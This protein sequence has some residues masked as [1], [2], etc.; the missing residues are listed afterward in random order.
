M[1]GAEGRLEKLA[2]GKP[3]LVRS[4]GV[5]DWTSISMAAI[6]ACDTELLYSSMGVE[7]QHSG[8]IMGREHQRCMLMYI[9]KL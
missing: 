7:W 6:M 8:S 4:V 9:I 5:A 3:R 1:R 2:V